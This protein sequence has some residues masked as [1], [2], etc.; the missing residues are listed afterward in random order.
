MYY[1]SFF[2]LINEGFDLLYLVSVYCVFVVVLR[3]R[4][5]LLFCGIVF[6][7][8]GFR[9]YFVKFLWRLSIKSELIVEDL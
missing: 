6:I 3:F 9:M 1:D 7:V 5:V 8:C 2:C 4:G